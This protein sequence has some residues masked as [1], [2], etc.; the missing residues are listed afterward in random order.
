MKASAIFFILL[1]AAL[2]I[3]SFAEAADP[4]GNVVAMEGRVSAAA[5][6]SG[7]V[8]PLGTGDP[9]Y[10]NDV[11]KTAEKAKLQILFTDDTL[12]AMGENS[13]ATISEYLFNPADKKKNGMGISM[14][15]GLFR[16]IT[17]KITTLNPERFSLK[18]TRATIGIRGCE[19]GF[20]LTPKYDKIMIIRVPKGK[21]IYIDDIPD[22]VSGRKGAL[23]PPVRI[24]DGGT[25][26]YLSDTDRPQKSKLSSE[27]INDILNGTGPGR[28]KSHA[29]QGLSHQGRGAG[30]GGAKGQHQLP[31][32][33]E[34]GDDPTGPLFEEEPGFVPPVEPVDQPT[35]RG[36]RSISRDPIPKPVWNGPDHSYHYSEPYYPPYGD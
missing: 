30:K 2:I 23:F 9:I 12:F 26:L 13:E 10:L 29:G 25:L 5:G 4:V 11:I 17:G 18:S 19:L 31:G 32:T 33:K 6:S 1:A 16:V 20:I 27:D 24:F 34:V 14:G 21:E 28:G 22:V 7:K 15:M 36:G 35:Q 8:R 3:P